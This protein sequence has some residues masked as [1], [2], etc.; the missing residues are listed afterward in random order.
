MQQLGIKSKYDC[1]MNELNQQIES[2]NEKYTR[3][4]WQNN[5]LK[6]EK[7][8]M[9]KFLRSKDPKHKNFSWNYFI[10]ITNSRFTHEK[11]KI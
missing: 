3:A 5:L 6:L 2:Q 4:V 7:D 8:R 10:D 1:K 9:L 11:E